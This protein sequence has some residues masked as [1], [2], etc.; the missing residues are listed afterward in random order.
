MYQKLLTKEIRNRLPALYSTEQQKNYDDAIAQIKF[1]APDSS[2]YWFATEGGPILDED[3]PT[4]EIDYHFFGLV[5]GH[6][7]ELGYFSLSELESARGPWGLKI[8]RDMDFEPITLRE[9]KRSE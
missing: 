7:A 6:E 8:E 4:K 1:F 5:F 9:V 2:W 3:D